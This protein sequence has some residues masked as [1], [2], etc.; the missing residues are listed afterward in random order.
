MVQGP[1]GRCRKL[2][3]E[4]SP[5]FPSPEEIS[6]W[7]VV[8]FGDLLEDLITPSLA[9]SGTTIDIPLGRE[10]GKAPD[11]VSSGHMSSPLYDRVIDIC[12]S[13]IRLWSPDYIP[14]ITS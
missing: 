3:F 2:P 9:V 10:P 4:V 14:E 7:K 12:P 5:E 13:I 8:L 6:D 11:P 1:G